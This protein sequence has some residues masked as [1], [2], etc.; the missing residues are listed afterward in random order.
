[1]KIPLDGLPGNVVNMLPDPYRKEGFGHYDIVMATCVEEL[2]NIA[3]A[4]HTK[5]WL[6]IWNNVHRSI[7]EF[8]ELNSLVDNW[9][10]DFNKYYSW[11]EDDGSE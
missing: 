9:I 6:D 10:I 4:R 11:S 3:C 1:M 5:N 8:M 2:K 7:V